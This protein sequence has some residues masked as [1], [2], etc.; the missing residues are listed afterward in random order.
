MKTFWDGGRTSSFFR[1]SQWSP[2]WIGLQGNSIPGGQ[3]EKR[4]IHVQNFH[5]VIK[6]KT[7]KTPT[8]GLG[9][10]RRKGDAFSEV[11][12]SLTLS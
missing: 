6:K 1:R 5:H 8:V 4:S 11:S 3:A 9:R 7:K 10:F 12:H 2:G